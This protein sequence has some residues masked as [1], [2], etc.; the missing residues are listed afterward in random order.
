VFP[1]LKVAV[2]STGDEL[3]PVGQPLKEGQNLRH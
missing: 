1:R 3:V 2:L